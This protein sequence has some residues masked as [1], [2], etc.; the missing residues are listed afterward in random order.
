LG[1]RMMVITKYT[2]INEIITAYPETLRFF[3]DLKM[4]CGGCFAVNFDTLEN[5]ALMH[6]MDVN[7]LIEQLSRF[8][9]GQSN[10]IA[11]NRKV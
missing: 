10:A 8:L 11:C 1:V 5:G 9:E 7:R 3:N 2:T 4:S 6:G